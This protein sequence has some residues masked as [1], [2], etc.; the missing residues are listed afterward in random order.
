MSKT[1]PNKR[2][3]DWRDSA[4]FTSIFLASGFFCSQAE[5]TPTPA[6]QPT[7][8]VRERKPLARPLLKYTST[9]KV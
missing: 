4:R 2:A 8:I 6:P 1:P 5:S 3:V 9:I 7:G